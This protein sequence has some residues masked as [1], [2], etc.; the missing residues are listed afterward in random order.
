M[1]LRNPDNVIKGGEG[2]YLEGNKNCAMLIHGGGG[3]TAAD[4]RELGNYINK[5][6]GYSVFAPLL[7]GFGTNEKELYNIQINDWFNA[8]DQW[9]SELKEEFNKIFLIGHSMGGVFALYLS[10]K[11]TKDVNAIVSISA[12]TK[13]KGFLIKLIPIVKIFIKYWKVNDIEEFQKISNG[14]WVGYERIPLN[15]IPKFKKL[16]K[17]TNSQLNKITAPILIIQGKNDQIVP[18]SSPIKIYNEVSSKIKR[19]EWLDAKHE[20]LFS[21]VKMELFKIISDFIIQY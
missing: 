5:N 19:I 15:L 12:P 6:I 11:Y 20:I 1:N 10:S 13:F 8:L 17:I 2:F 18:K 7:P 3:G 4:M 16:I 14:I 9:F 21:D